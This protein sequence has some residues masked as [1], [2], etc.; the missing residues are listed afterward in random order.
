LRHGVYLV[1]L[2][3]TNF[4]ILLPNLH[5]RNVGNIPGIRFHRHHEFSKLKTDPCDVRTAQ[6]RHM[7]NSVQQM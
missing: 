1:Q 5:T 3:D 2:S 4:K 6:A 7:N